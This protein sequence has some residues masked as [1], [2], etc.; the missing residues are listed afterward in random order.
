MDKIAAANKI[1][2]TF[3]WQPKYDLDAMV[4]SAL[5]WE[6]LL[7]AAPD[8]VHPLSVAPKN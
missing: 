3:G 8:G 1:Q 2:E 4:I 5:K 7:A 6:R